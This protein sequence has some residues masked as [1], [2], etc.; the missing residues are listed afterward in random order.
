MKFALDCYACAL[1]HTL[2]AARRAGMDEA[3]QSKALQR[4]L[5]ILVDLKA[6]SASAEIMTK[7]HTIIREITGIEDVYHDEKIESTQEALALYP[8]LKEEISRS[9]DPLETAARLSIAGNIIDYGAFD[10]YDLEGTIRRVMEQPFAINDLESLRNAIDKADQILY[11]AD[12]AGETVF[13]RLLIETIQKPVVYAVKE[14][15]ILNDATLE[16][17]RMAGLDKVAELVS[18]GASCPGTL[19]EQCSTEFIER[20]RQAELIIAKGMGNYEALSDVAAPI[21][22]LLQVKCELVAHNLSVP[23]GSIVVVKSNT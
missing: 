22:F 6:D 23:K 3:D 17:A 20:F 9:T 8:Q 19:L 7:T 16:D 14:S 18:C 5:Q 21:Y 1:R 10:G 15:P 13:D 12:N 11:L 4:V 2:E